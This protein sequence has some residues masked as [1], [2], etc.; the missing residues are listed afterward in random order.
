M[1]II[2]EMAQWSAIAL[3]AVVTVM[4]LTIGIWHSQAYRLDDLQDEVDLLR[5]QLNKTMIEEGG[6]ELAGIQQSLQKVEAKLDSNIETISLVKYAAYSA[7][8]LSGFLLVACIFLVARIRSMGRSGT[9][10][11]V[12]DIS[13]RAA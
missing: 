8:G 4:P 7:I 6:L 11:S 10:A 2:N 13:K 1:K 5:T 9:K 12:T 3:L